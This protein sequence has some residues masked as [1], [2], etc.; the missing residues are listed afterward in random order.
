MTEINLFKTENE[1]YV[2]VLE[3][4]LHSCFVKIGKGIPQALMLNEVFETLTVRGA[5]NNFLFVRQYQI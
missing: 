1:K 3:S 2:E 4:I 5:K